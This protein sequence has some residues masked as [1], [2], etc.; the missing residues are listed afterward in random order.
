MM[1]RPGLPNER[2][3]PLT[4]WG[5]IGDRLLGRVSGLL[6]RYESTPVTGRPIAYARAHISELTRFAF[7]GASLQLLNLAFLY[8]LRVWLR[9]SDPIAVTGMYVLGV[10]AHFPTQRW[11]TYGAQHRPVVPQL[12]RYALMLVWNFA[13]MQSVVGLASRA[14]ISPYIAVMIATVLTMVSNFVIMTHI[15]FAKERR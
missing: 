7:T 1:T 11:I 10:L 6:E 13:I 4:A 5:S 3:V 2:V 15:V 8:A 9:L 12:R 14:S